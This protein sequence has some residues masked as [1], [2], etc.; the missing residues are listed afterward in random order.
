MT[1]ALTDATWHEASGVLA[2]VWDDGCQAR[3]SAARLRAACKCAGCE[4]L[5]RNGR[6]PQAPAG[7]A[8]AQ[9]NPIGQMGVQ[10]V[11]ADGHD[12]GIYPWPYLHQLSLEACA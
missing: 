5:R 4:Q 2:L 11:F 7:T 3:L 8:L 9:I 6:P 10:L 1:A 12:R